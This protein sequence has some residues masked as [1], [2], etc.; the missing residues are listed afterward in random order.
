MLSDSSGLETLHL[1]SLSLFFHECVSFSYKSSEYPTLRTY[2][3]FVHTSN[4][5][6]MHHFLCHHVAIQ[7]QSSVGINSSLLE[8]VA[9]FSLFLNQSINENLILYENVGHYHLLTLENFVLRRSLVQQL[10]ILPQISYFLSHVSF[11]VLTIP[12]QNFYQLEYRHPQNLC[13]FTHNKISTMTHEDVVTH[14]KINSRCLN[15]SSCLSLNTM[16][17]FLQYNSF[18]FHK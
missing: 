8:C 3:I 12:P 4:L 16:C 15:M 2:I 10:Q 13:L 9:I 18:L 1:F 7:L 17:K 14:I 11:L 5:L 6:G